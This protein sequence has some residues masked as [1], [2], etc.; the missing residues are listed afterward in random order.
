MADAGKKY[1]THTYLSFF[2]GV[3]LANNLLFKQD[4]SKALPL[5][6]IDDFPTRSSSFSKA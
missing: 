3:I 4:F 1:D 5:T 2:L 6:R